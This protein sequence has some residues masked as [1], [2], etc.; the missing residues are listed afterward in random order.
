[1]ATNQDLEVVTILDS[2]THEHTRDGAT[3]LIRFVR[4]FNGAGP[5]INPRTYQTLVEKYNNMLH[6]MESTQKI[7]P[8]ALINHGPGKP[9]SLLYIE[10]CGDLQKAYTSV[11]MELSTKDLLL[12]VYYKNYIDAVTGGF[13]VLSGTA[14]DDPFDEA[15]SAKVGYRAQTIIAK[16]SEVKTQEIA[17][18]LIEPGNAKYYPKVMKALSVDEAGFA[19]A[20]DAAEFTEIGQH[21]V[22]SDNPDN[23][24]P[25]GYNADTAKKIKTDGAN[26]EVKGQTLVETPEFK[27]QK[28]IPASTN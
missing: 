2:N 21:Q 22:G 13:V 6:Y 7:T 17:L 8:M 9:W 19:G 24:T 20:P 23:M 15:T 27:K 16:V 28:D 12:A 10:N 14:K 25:S 18:G 4:S 3:E 11:N 26:L 1:M 5:A